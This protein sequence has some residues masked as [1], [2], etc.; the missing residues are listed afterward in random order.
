MFNFDRTVGIS[1]YN[2]ASKTL[3]AIN[4]VVL[5]LRLILYAGMTIHA[6]GSYILHLCNIKMK[7][8]WKYKYIS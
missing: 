6:S 7:V 3:L 2:H 1:A 8:D 5:H 4:H